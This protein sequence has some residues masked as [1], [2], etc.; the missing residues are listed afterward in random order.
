[1]A[2]NERVFGF[3]EATSKAL[4]GLVNVSDKSPLRTTANIFTTHMRLGK[5]VGAITAGNTGSVYL[6][7]PDDPGTGWIVDTGTT[8]T[9][10]AY[11][12]ALPSDVHVMCFSV[13][14]R[15]LCFEICP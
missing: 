6:Q 5:T 7:V 8:F 9:A 3:K 14:G 4:L 15:W 11:P 12:T 1:M 2:E 10:W 13:N